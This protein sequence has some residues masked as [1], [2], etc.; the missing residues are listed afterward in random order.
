MIYVPK[1]GDEF[2]FHEPNNDYDQ[3]GYT[4]K[5]VGL[6][7]NGVI[8]TVSRRRNTD[9]WSFSTSTWTLPFIHGNP[10]YFKLP[11]QPVT[12]DAIGYM[13]IQHCK[14]RIGAT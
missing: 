5:V 6:R 11:N 8:R 9:N 3:N 10:K 12:K 4:F 14:A 7:D 13:L 1:I 2:V